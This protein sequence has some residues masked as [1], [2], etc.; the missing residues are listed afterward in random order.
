MNKKILAQVIVV[1]LLVVSVFGEAFVKA[2]DSIP[3]YRVE[4]WIYDENDPGAALILLLSEWV[5]GEYVLQDNEG[6][7]V[8][9][10]EGLIA[11]CFDVE[12]DYPDELIT[13]F[14]YQEL[15]LDPSLIEVEERLRSVLFNGYPNRSLSDLESAAGIEDLTFAQAIK[16]TQYAIWYYTNDA[17]DLLNSEETNAYALY[18][19]LIALD[20]MTKLNGLVLS[21]L[22]F[23]S[24]DVNVN[25]GK[26]TFT[27]TYEL[28]ASGK[29]K[30]L[31]NL[32][33]V[34]SDASLLAHPDAELSYEFAADI[35]VIDIT[36]SNVTDLETISFDFN[37]T[38]TTFVDDVFYLPGSNETVQDLGALVSNL[39]TENFTD[40]LTFD[41]PEVP[42]EPE[43]PE[44][45]EVPEEPVV[46][47]V[48]EVP[49]APEAPEL[50]STGMSDKPLLWA[51][52]MIVLGMFL[53]IVK[54]KQVV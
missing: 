9:F 50:P 33:V 17:D 32:D 49:E 38:T 20:P 18:E 54:K 24:R 27:A 2:D 29:Q 5:D 21:D 3:K 31:D 10:S 43:V 44:A 26:T 35:L 34:L 39:K 53:V 8:P 52:A 7:P 19:Y 16:G 37:F 41:V 46:P 14:N 13:Y 22:D 15:G 25:E 51:K 28:N 40:T 47:G 6:M 45:P 12:K 4:T 42:E 1:L 36:L 48:P 30:D 11:Y 23:L